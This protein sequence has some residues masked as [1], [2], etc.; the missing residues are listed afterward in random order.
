MK[1]INRIEPVTLIVIREARDEH[2]FSYD[3]LDVRI[4]TFEL[5]GKNPE[6]G[7]YVAIYV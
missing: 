1:I 6:V 2:E 5:F 3:G 7:L 4:L